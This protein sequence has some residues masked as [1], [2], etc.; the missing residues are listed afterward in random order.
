MPCPTTTS[1]RSEPTISATARAARARRHQP[2]KADVSAGL[3][4]A[5][6][7]RPLQKIT[8]QLAEQQRRAPS[9][10][11]DSQADPNSGSAV[12]PSSTSSSS[13]TT[14]Q[15]G[16]AGVAPHELLNYR[17]FLPSYSAPPVLGERRVVRESPFFEVK[18]KNQI[19]LFHSEAPSAAV[20]VHDD[21]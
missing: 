4:A 19:T 21:T 15:K 5:A 17:L 2:G 3:M 13:S 10:Q 20:G 8:N 1:R 16:K 11:H 18:K 6:A 14:R 12:R 7:A 9:R